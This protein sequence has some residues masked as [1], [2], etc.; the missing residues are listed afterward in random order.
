MLTAAIVLFV[1]AALLG[2]FNLIA[3]LTNKAT[4]KPVVFAH[5]AAAAV[6]LLIV[7]F[8]TVKATGASPTTSLI[9]FVLAATGGFVL[10]A[11]D[12]TKR[13]IPKA[14]AVIH[15]LVAAAG[16]ASLVAF[17]LGH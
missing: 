16:L 5:G 12:M 13:P 11:M 4:S 8:A 1:I 9:L 17:V 15:P 10:F 7:V 3:V 14:L 6:A 2:A